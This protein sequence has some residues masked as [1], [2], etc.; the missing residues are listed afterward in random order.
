M[1][2]R[3]TPSRLAF[4]VALA[5]GA[6]AAARA[7]AVWEFTPKIE[8]G[9]LYDDNY[10]LTQPGTEIQVNGPMLDAALDM[11]TLTQTGQFTFTPRV[12]ATYFAK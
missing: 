4:A 9:Y 6:G 3:L 2:A 10:R 1:N 7:D 11:T 5:L 8:A 12:R